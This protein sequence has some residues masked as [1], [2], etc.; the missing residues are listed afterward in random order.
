MA[1]RDFGKVESRVQVPDVAPKQH[2]EEASPRRASSS[3]FFGRIAQLGERMAGSH[4]VASSSLAA[5][6]K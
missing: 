4:E 5:S 2:T 1:K 3:V 6:T